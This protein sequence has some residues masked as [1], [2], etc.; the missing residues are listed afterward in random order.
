[1]SQRRDFI[2]QSLTER[3]ARLESQIK[4]IPSKECNS[5]SAGS[6]REMV[7]QDNHGFEEGTIVYCPQLS[8]TETWKRAWGF[9]ALAV[10]GVNSSLYTTGIFGVVSRVIGSNLFEV[11][12]SGLVDKLLLSPGLVIG[13][14]DNHLSLY[15]TEDWENPGRAVN[16]RTSSGMHIANIVR[17][18]DLKFNVN[19]YCNSTAS[20]TVVDFSFDYDPINILQ[21]VQVKNGTVSFVTS[22]DNPSPA[23]IKLL[24]CKYSTT[25]AVV[26]EHGIVT[27]SAVIQF[28]NVYKNVYP[29]YLKSDGSYAPDEFWNSGGTEY[30]NK[31]IELGWAAGVGR[32]YFAPR[33]T[34]TLLYDF[35][36]KFTNPHNPI[37]ELEDGH[38]LIWDSEEEKFV[39]GFAGFGGED[40][41]GPC[42]VA[43][44]NAGSDKLK[45]YAADIDNEVL[46]RVGGVLAWEK[47][48][49]AQMQKRAAYSTLAN[50]SDTHG[51]L[52][53]VTAQ[54]GTV[55][56]RGDA[57]MGFFSDVDL[58][59]EDEG[60]GVFRVWF[61]PN[62]FF[63]VLPSGACGIYHAEDNKIGIEPDVTFKCV[64]GTNVVQLN[65]AHI[66][67]TGR[68]IQ[69]REIDVCDGG[70]Q[71]K[72]L[73]LASAPY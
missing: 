48:G 57:N 47:V 66:V 10:K 70:V 46:M 58:G 5:G 19:P 71:K 39:P 3:I 20:F 67:G 59:T 35:D 1:M 61:A 14:Q 25:K 65:P 73:I 11:T 49:L 13:E 56:S 51:N 27:A 45:L 15:V 60:E 41:E 9:S 12:L 69:L 44:P 30:G 53:E 34:P 62:K 55:F 54:I 50:V 2:I 63:C 17:T 18:P 7:R 38:S 43:Q 23:E 16:I 33:S 64:W 36:V 29:V 52:T 28:A 32:F 40:V 26:V 42:I 22:Q 6:L 68:Q 21:F 8:P 24:L 72:M 31:K 4:Q 37:S